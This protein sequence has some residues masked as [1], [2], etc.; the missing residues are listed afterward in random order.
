MSNSGKFEK[1]KWY[2][3]I[4]FIAV[5]IVAYEFV[6]LISYELILFTDSK[7]MTTAIPASLFGVVTFVC[8]KIQGYFIKKRSID[9]SDPNLE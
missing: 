4:I 6:E 9:S 3:S 1:I 5:L 7:L 8:L 2:D